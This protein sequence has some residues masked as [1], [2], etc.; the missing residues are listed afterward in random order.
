MLCPIYHR[1]RLRV[2]SVACQLPL[3][4]TIPYIYLPPRALS[5][6]SWQFCIP[7]LVNGAAYIPDRK[8][9]FMKAMLE[10]AQRATMASTDWLTK[11]EV[12]SE[13]FLIIFPHLSIGPNFKNFMFYIARIF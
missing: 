12:A 5:N 13:P 8:T 7:Q 4:L 1:G 6:S 3:Q 11:D 10:Q 2:S 9:H